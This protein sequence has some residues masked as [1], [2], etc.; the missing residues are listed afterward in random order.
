MQHSTVHVVRTKATATLNALRGAGRAALLSCIALTAWGGS[1]ALAQDGAPTPP[2]VKLI[3]LESQADWPTRR[4]FGRVV[5]RRTIDLAFQ[6]AG[7]I[8]EIPI[9]EGD[10]LDEG[11]LIATLDLEP[12]ELA[13]ERARLERERAERAYARLERLGP[14][15]TSQ[16]SIDD[17]A[18]AQSLASVAEREAARALR[19][20]TVK[21][22]FKALVAQRYLDAF[23]TV[24]T[25]QAIVRLHDMSEVRVEINVPEI[26]FRRAQSAEEFVL[27]ATL[28]GDD[29]PYRLAAR[30]F[31]AET[32][33]IGQTFLIT[34]AF[35][36]E[37][38]QRLL[39]G[40]D[41][42]RDCDPQRAERRRL[43]A[44]ERDRHRCGPRHQRHAV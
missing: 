43:R 8:A 31:N 18:T 1:A 23:T 37:T 41:R 11:E 19:E 24:A 4:F 5:A 39:P 9:E 42:D 16:A 2:P 12:F 40:R 13:L 15:T 32:S 14:A 35:V 38:D 22:P 27:Y 20:A 17:A 21:A 25:G 6:V 34:L 3:T 26:L 10:V 36:G 7:Q 30:E 28:T 44:P 29:R 33:Q